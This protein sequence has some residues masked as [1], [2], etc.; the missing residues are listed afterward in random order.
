MSIRTTRALL[1]KCFAHTEYVEDL[2]SD[3]FNGK[4]VEQAYTLA[5][6]RYA[7]AGVDTELALETLSAVALSLHC[8]QGDDVGGFEFGGELRRLHRNRQ[9]SWQSALLTNCVGPGPG[10]S[11]NPGS[12]PLEPARHLC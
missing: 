11:L 4:H 6:E 8:W 5:R 2:M 3:E 1:A 7:A 9:L 10:L 12:A